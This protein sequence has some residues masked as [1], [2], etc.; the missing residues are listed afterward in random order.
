M[1]IES[2]EDGIYEVSR[3]DNVTIQVT[4]PSG[5]LL[6]GWSAADGQ[7]LGTISADLR[8]MTVYDIASD[9]DYTVKY[10]APNRYKVT[11]GADDDA[12]GVV[13]AVAAGSTDALVSGD[14]LLQG[15][16][17]VFTATP[18]EGYEVAYWEVNGEKV[19]AEAE[20][21][22]AQRYELEYLGKDTKVV[23]YFYKQP[24]VSWTS[25]NDTEM[26]AKSGDSDLA[27]GGCIAYASKDDLKFTFAVK[28]NYEI[29][30]I[31]VNY[32][33]EDVFSLAENSGE[34][35]LAETADAESG[36]ERYTFTWSAP[37][38]GFTGDVTVN[39]TY[40][41]ITPSVKAEYSLKVIE[42][43]SAGESSGKTHGS[44]SADVSRKNLPSY[45]QIGD[46]ISDAT[47]SKSAQITDIYR[48]SVI[49]FKVVP[50]DGY[51]VKEWIINGH[52]L[53]SETENIK[54]YSDKKV[55]DT[56]KITVDGDSSDVTVMAGLELVGDVLTFGPETEGT[57]EVSAMIT[58]TK[59]VL[60][61]QRQL[62]KDTKLQ[63][64]L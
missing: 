36:T 4:V 12:A 23:V 41:K 34:G 3:G 54:L 42:K 6:A 31:K 48:D 24:V 29:A 18:N 17:I 64:G 43:A 51:N 44:I 15:S 52:K 8:T 16:D 27:N 55:N 56:L 40:R 45:I 37:A 50:D 53:T 60:E 9:L 1:T 22:G 21:T 2:G 11:Y 61:S 28:R 32:A 47:E 33:G 20:G 46:T 49:T 63:T 59:L 38:D 57:G 5:L 58:S 14:K 25:G 62:Q 30:D 19:D 13:E 10:T 35:K 7:E 39:A 26:T